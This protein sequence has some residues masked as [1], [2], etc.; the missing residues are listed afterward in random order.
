MLKLICKSNVNGIIKETAH[1]GTVDTATAP[2]TLD[3][4]PEELSESEFTSINVESGCGK[5]G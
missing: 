5:K 1:H 3:M 2:Q 4:K